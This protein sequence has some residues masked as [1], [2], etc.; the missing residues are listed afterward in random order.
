MAAYIPDKTLEYLLDENVLF[1]IKTQQ[2][3]YGTSAAAYKLME[4]QSE[5]A[6]PVHPFFTTIQRHLHEAF[7]FHF[8]GRDAGHGV[9]GPEEA[10]QDRERVG[11]EEAAV[12]ENPGRAR[13]QKS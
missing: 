8:K 13:G 6:F 4:T 2:A 12:P 10:V 5:R 11:G 7:F 9:H 1:K 3:R